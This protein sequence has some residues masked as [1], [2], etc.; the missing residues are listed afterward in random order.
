MLH[1]Y[2]DVFWTCILN[3]PYNISVL[4]YTFKIE[5]LARAKCITCTNASMEISDI[6]SVN[7]YVFG[8]VILYA[9]K[10]VYN[11]TFY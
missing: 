3:I 11:Y 9:N 1:M 4:I 2:D 7:I 10:K 8:D 5:S 6:I